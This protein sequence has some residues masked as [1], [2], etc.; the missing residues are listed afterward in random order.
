[1][2]YAALPG[3]AGSGVIDHLERILQQDAARRRPLT[4]RERQE[5]IPPFETDMRLLEP[6][7]GEDFGDWLGPRGD[8]GGL[9]VPGRAGAG[10]QRAAAVPLIATPGSSP[11]PPSMERMPRR[12]EFL[13]AEVPYR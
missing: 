11:R 3:Q 1:M 7:T 2:Q 10:S 9:V 4:W 8:T 5:P 13:V 12:A 6:V